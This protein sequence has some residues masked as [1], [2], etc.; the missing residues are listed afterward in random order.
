MWVLRVAIVIIAAGAMTMAILVN[1]IY[2]LWYL[3]ADF[4][5]VI[6]FPQLLLVFYMEDSNSYG[7]FFGFVLGLFFRLT[8]G[9]PLLSLP[10]L[11]RYPKYDEESGYQLIPFKTMCMVI[12]LLVIIIFSY[13][14][15]FLF[16]RWKVL[17]LS[18]DVFNSFGERESVQSISY[19]KTEHST[20]FN[21]DAFDAENEPPP[22]QEVIDEKTEDNI[23]ND[24]TA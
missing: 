12:T 20:E 15:K 11:I 24:P 7:A 23:K 9:E 6:L 22:Y 2:G 13:L 5:Y 18:L 1:S 10:P 3:C 17:P 16:T 19:K 4:V 21:N 8:G 14:F